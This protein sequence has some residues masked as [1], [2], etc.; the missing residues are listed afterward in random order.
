MQLWV[1]KVSIFRLI[2]Q[3]QRFDI[4]ERLLALVL[5]INSYSVRLRNVHCIRWL[6]QIIHAV[7]DCVSRVYRQRISLGIIC[8][9]LMVSVRNVP[10]GKCYV[11]DMNEQWL[12]CR[13]A[14]VRTTKF[15]SGRLLLRSCQDWLLQRRHQI[16][17]ARFADHRQNDKV[18]DVLST[19][20]WKMRLDVFSTLSLWFKQHH[21]LKCRSE[22]AGQSSSISR[23]Q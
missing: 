19:S 15:V 21:W 2:D 20:V 8:H 16:I 4:E 17:F 7:L 13:I 1:G 23:S 14:G 11:M 5:L 18:R 6:C 22:I 9:G 10:A 3:I 12:N